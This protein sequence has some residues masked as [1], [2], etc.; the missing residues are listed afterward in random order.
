MLKTIKHLLERSA[1]VISISITVLII[2][3]SLSSLKELNLNI[4]VSDKILHV[5]AYLVLTISWLFAIKKSHNN[6]K[7]KLQIGL[8]LLVFGIIIEILQSSMPLNRSG[9][10]FDVLAN[11]SGILLA[12]IT[13]NYLFRFYKV[14]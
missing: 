10:Y 1:Y 3:L 12:I 8:V 11:S 7:I 4:S 14:I 13:F 9:D 2:Y 5:F 6:F